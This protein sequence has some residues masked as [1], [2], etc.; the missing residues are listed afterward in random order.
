MLAINLCQYFVQGIHDKRSL[1]HTGMRDDQ[2]GGLYAAFVIKQY[3][4]VDRAVLIDCGA[5][6]GSLCGVNVAFPYAVLNVLGAV[7]HL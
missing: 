2:V 6:V 7:K 1:A 5:V 4:D 3:V